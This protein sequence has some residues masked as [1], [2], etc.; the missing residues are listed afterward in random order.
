LWVIVALACILF[1]VILLLCVPVEFK[2]SARINESPS[3][4]VRF[5]WLFGLINKELRKKEKKP[6]TQRKE[7]KAKQKSSANAS[8]FFTIIKT[9]G[10]FKQLWL[11]VKSLA[12]SF[13]I[14]KALVHVNLGFENPSDTALLY[15]LAGPI[16]YLFNKP[17]YDIQITPIFDVDLYFDAY[18]DVIARVIPLF[19]VIGILG[20]VFSLPVFNIIK[21]VVVMRWKKQ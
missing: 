14:K 3:C 8:T 10:L 4:H 7:P 16:N 6:S 2:F 17:P 1:L 11:L 18:L 19:M 13:T 21:T 15:A 12:R 9:R 20:F 5:L